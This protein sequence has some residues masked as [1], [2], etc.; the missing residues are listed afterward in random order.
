MNANVNYVVENVIQIKSRKTI[1]ADVRTKNQENVCKKDYIWNLSACI[2]DNG[3]CLNSIAG[4]SV[5][6]S[7]EFWRKQ[8]LF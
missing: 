6:T 8:K 7:D 3:K 4:D 2:C 1:N 5:I